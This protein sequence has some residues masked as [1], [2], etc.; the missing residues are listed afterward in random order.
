M[1]L[2]TLN[3]PY[4]SNRVTRHLVQ[5]RSKAQTLSSLVIT[6]SCG[7]VLLAA[8]M[9][10]AWDGAVEPDH[11]YSPP[12]LGNGGHPVDPGMPD[13][14][15]R[16]LPRCVTVG[17]TVIVGPGV[18]VESGSSGEHGGSANDGAADKRLHGCPPGDP[19][20]CKPL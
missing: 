6:L 19:T 5:E 7:A 4:P 12:G 18:P 17:C 3:Q 9:M 15:H 13:E 8:G 10:P 2:S 1:T 11:P 16:P 14:P 20:K